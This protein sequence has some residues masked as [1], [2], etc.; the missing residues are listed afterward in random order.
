[1]I[2]KKNSICTTPSPKKQTNTAIA[3]IV[4]FSFSIRPTEINLTKRM[5]KN[6]E[7]KQEDASIPKMREA[8]T[9]YGDLSVGKKPKA[10]EYSESFKKS[11]LSVQK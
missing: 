1:M 3:R 6:Q 11:F 7:K 5:P 4:N 9:S 10:Y 8:H 2:K